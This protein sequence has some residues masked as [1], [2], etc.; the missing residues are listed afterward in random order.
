MNDSIYLLINQIDSPLF[1]KGGKIHIKKKNRG[2]LTASAKRA[3]MGVQEFARHVLANKDKYSPTL[4]KRAAFAKGIGGSQIKKHKHKN[5][6]ILKAQ[7][8]TGNLYA[9]H[10]L[11]PVG[12]ALNQA[13]AM[14]KGKTPLPPGVKEVVGPDGKKIA[15]R[16]E[17][18]LVP[19][20]QSIAEW[21][22]GTGDV[23]EVGYIADDVKNGNLG[24]ATLGAGLL[25]LPGNA[26]KLLKTN[27]GKKISNFLN[28]DIFNYDELW[29][30][31][32]HPTWQKYYHGSPKEFDIK[33][34]YKGT[35]ADSGL[36]M[37]DRKEVAEYFAENGPYNPDKSTVYEFYAPKPTMEFMDLHKNGINM[38]SGNTQQIAGNHLGRGIFHGT[39]HGQLEYRALRESGGEDVIDFLPTYTNDRFGNTIEPYQLK[40]DVTIPIE[41][42]HWPDRPKHVDD[43]LKEMRKQYDTAI[44]NSDYDIVELLNSEVSDIMAENGHPVIKYANNNAFEGGGMSYMLFDRSK[45]HLINP[46]HQFKMKHALTGLGTGLGVS[47]GISRLKDE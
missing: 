30:R 32:K 41:K 2:K 5:G 1:K 36:H 14:A 47:Y 33:N 4:V 10:P 26:G 22:P 44:E 42:Y 20:E 40:R 8:G 25:L 6:G 43:R 12:I 28:K 37:S 35:V 3:G 9:P 31:I 13:K 17:Q 38:L 16:T 27:V 34:F 19:L 46:E 15:I 18:P 7:E 29:A 11:S 23:A 39:P 21:L 45:L 24:S